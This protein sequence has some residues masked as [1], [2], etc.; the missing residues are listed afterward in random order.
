MIKSKGTSLLHAD[1]DLVSKYFEYRD[2]FYGDQMCEDYVSD[3][4]DSCSE[5]FDMI[6]ER[7]KSQRLTTG[8]WCGQ[9]LCLADFCI[10]S[11]FLL[12]TEKE[13]TLKPLLMDSYCELRPY[14]E[15]LVSTLEIQ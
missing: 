4:L 9:D 14:I 12:I 1:D 8:F 5:V 11:F 15:R 2:V 13:P 7:Y 3:L 6:R 10:G